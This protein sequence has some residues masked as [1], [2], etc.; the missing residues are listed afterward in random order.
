MDLSRQIDGLDRSLVA[1]VGGIYCPYSLLTGEKHEHKSNGDFVAVHED[2][3]YCSC[4]SRALVK[5]VNGMRFDLLTGQNRFKPWVVITK[6]RLAL[7][8][9]SVGQ[10]TASLEASMDSGV[11]VCGEGCNYV[12][13]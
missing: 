7:L 6:E 13:S 4:T 2:T 5:N 9:S 8:S 11:C 3:V 1:R 12:Y 10:S